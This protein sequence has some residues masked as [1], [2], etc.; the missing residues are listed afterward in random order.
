MNVDSRDKFRKINLLLKIQ[1]LLII[2]LLLRGRHV[3][4]LYFGCAT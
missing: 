2:T 3:N 4:I 1:H